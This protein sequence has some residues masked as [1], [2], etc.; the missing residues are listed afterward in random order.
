MYYTGYTV[1][2]NSEDAFH[3]WNHELLNYANSC[4]FPRHL[5]QILKYAKAHNCSLSAQVSKYYLHVTFNVQRVISLQLSSE[6]QSISLH[7]DAVHTLSY[8]DEH[9]EVVNP[10]LNIDRAAAQLLERANKCTGR[11][12]EAIVLY[13]L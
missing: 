2:I 6:L 5:V 10:L 1:N 4:H 7:V 3:T 11:F 8:T 12:G 13:E 9:G